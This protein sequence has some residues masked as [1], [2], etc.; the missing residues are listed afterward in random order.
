MICS[1]NRAHNSAVKLKGTIH[2]FSAN[3]VLAR[4]IKG[5]FNYPVE[6]EVANLAVG[7]LYHY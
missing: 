6:R 4:Q 3:S 2:A 5:L 1:A 7:L